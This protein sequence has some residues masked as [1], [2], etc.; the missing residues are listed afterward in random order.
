MTQ[1]TVRS[2]RDGAVTTVILDRPEVKNGVDG[3]TAD[4]LAQVFLAF[5]RDERQ[6]VRS[7][8]VRAAHSV[9]VQT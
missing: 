1:A 5:E 6:A 2:E 7:F 9:P 8:G 4:A 3:P